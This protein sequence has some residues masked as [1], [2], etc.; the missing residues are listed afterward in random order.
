M[1]KVETVQICYNKGFW[2]QNYLSICRTRPY[3]TANLR[4][5][6]FFAELE[7]LKLKNSDMQISSTPELELG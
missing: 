2:R 5:L 6:L 1:A 3:R 4:T 7:K